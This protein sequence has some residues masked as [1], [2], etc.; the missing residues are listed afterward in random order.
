MPR[1]AQPSVT[2]K[3]IA[4]VIDANCRGVSERAEGASAGSLWTA[5]A[6]I[7]SPITS[8]SASVSCFSGGICWSASAARFCHRRLASGWPGTT[9]TPSSP[10]LSTAAGVSSSSPPCWSIGPWH[11]TH[12]RSSSG[13]TLADQSAAGSSPRAAAATRS[14]SSTRNWVARRRCIGSRAGHGGGRTLSRIIDSRKRCQPR[15]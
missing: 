7:H 10:P 14:G 5:R 9:T 3:S 8:C 1:V 13:C 12:C 11:F 2:K 15:K 4:S 6:A